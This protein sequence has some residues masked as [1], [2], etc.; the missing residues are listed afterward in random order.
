MN[1]IILIAAALLLSL[2]FVWQTVG[3]TY[4]PLLAY[5]FNVGYSV[6]YQ[7]SV[8]VKILNA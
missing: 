7:D 6:T 1:K 4:K 2:H 5:G 3:Y 8:H